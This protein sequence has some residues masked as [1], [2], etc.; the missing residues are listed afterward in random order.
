[1]MP[2]LPYMTGTATIRSVYKIIGQGNQYVAQA[3]KEGYGAVG[4]D[5]IAGPSEIMISADQWVD[6]DL[7]LADSLSQARA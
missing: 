6:P 5:F 2:V 7:V 4:I 3:K 1:M